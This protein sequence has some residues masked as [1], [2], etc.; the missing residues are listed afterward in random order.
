MV[1]VSN[2]AWLVCASYSKLRAQHER[3][4]RRSCSCPAL[5]D[6][7]GNRLVKYTVK[8]VG[9]RMSNRSSATYCTLLST[10]SVW[11]FENEQGILGLNRNKFLPEAANLG[12][13]RS[14]VR[15][16]VVFRLNSP[17]SA[18]GVPKEQLR[19]AELGSK[20]CGFGERPPRVG[21]AAGGTSRCK[22]V[23]LPFRGCKER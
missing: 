3:K 8:V 21:P 18:V 20:R 9:S 4:C 16:K 10:A 19:R 17:E 23:L 1:S 11:L 5:P 22:H 6:I 14:W 7:S 13:L 12:A 2:F 15:E